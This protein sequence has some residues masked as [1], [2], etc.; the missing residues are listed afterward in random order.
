MQI[1]YYAI[2]LNIVNTSNFSSSFGMLSYEKE[3][4]ATMFRIRKNY[5]LLSDLDLPSYICRLCGNQNRSA[6]RYKFIKLAIKSTFMPGTTT[7]VYA[8]LRLLVPKLWKGNLILLNKPLPIQAA[9]R[10]S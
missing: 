3:G 8:L 5:A 1:A 9:I 2:F 7:A 10:L 4:I 6:G